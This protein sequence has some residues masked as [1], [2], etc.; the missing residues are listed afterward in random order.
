MPQEKERH[1]RHLVALGQP[2]EDAMKLDRVAEPAERRRFH[3]TQQHV[4]AARLRA[5]DHR[6][7]VALDRRD[8]HAA[9]AVVAADREDDDLRVRARVRASKRTQR[10]AGR[11]AS[12]A[13]VD[14]AV[15]APVAR[16][17]LLKQGRVGFV[18]A[19]ARAGGQAV[20]ERH[21]DRRALAGS[22]RAVLHCIRLLHSRRAAR[23]QSSAY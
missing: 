1:E 12:D 23:P 11:V 22:G 14:H 6:R 2:R 15:V 7:D 13:G 16:D 9:Q 17:P 20:A 5:L 10:L 3:L 8:R 4:D 19:Q 18:R 21:D